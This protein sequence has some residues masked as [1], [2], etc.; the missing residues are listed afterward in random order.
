MMTTAVRFVEFDWSHRVAHRNMSP[1][2]IPSLDSCFSSSKYLVSREVS[3]PT[4]WLRSHQHLSHLTRHS[5][6]PP[7]MRVM[8]LTFFF[9]FSPQ[10]IF[11]IFSIV[12]KLD[13]GSSNAN[14][15]KESFKHKSNFQ[16]FSV[17]FQ[18][19]YQILLH[20]FF[21]RNVATMTWCKVHIHAMACRSRKVSAKEAV[22]EYV[23]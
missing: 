10:Q 11:L 19:Y 2:N 21:H 1:H 15:S 4:Y 9:I 12:N 7:V 13:C 5:F 14:E 16:R 23:M 17:F 20:T 3:E 18:S 22:S 8:S 6:F